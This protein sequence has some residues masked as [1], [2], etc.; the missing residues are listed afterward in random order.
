MGLFYKMSDKKLLEIRNKIFCEDGIPVLEKNGFEQSPFPT[1]WYGKD[2]MG[3]YTYEL[4][5]LSNEEHLEIVTVYI[6]KGERWVQIHLNI[7]KLSPE[8]NSL[9]ELKETDAIKFYL[10][11]DSITKMRLRVD[12]IKGMPLFDYHFMFGGHKIKSYNSEN[13]LKKRINQLRRLIKKDLM[14]IDYFVER[15]HDIH[16]LNVTDWEGNKVNI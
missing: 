14:N 5:R 16:Q 8:L 1:S 10:P 2:D 12:D 11:P 9:E 7:F 3:G 13:G 4:C 15:W 6:I